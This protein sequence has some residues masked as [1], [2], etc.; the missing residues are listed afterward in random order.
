MWWYRAYSFDWCIHSCMCGWAQFSLFIPKILI[1]R[2]NYEGRQISKLVI[3]NY[4][5]TFFFTFVIV[6]DWKNG[7]SSFCSQFQLP[8]VLQAAVLLNKVILL[9]T[10]TEVLLMCITGQYWCSNEYVGPG[11]KHVSSQVFASPME[12]F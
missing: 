4:V 9:C 7:F 8:S 3:V 1:Y 12:S 5:Y 2:G 6:F 10:V 11:N